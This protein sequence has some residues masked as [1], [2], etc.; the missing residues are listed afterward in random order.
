MIR[1]EGS[2]FTGI[3]GK[4]ISSGSNSKCEDPE[5][6]L[7]PMSVKVWERER[8]NGI[9]LSTQSTWRNEILGLVSLLSCL[10]QNIPSPFLKKL[11]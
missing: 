9:A 11:E 8:L 7:S 3:K 4:G 5:A 6:G 10:P 1:P 2:G